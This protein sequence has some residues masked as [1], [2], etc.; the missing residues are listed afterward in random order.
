MNLDL[1]TIQKIIGDSR[2]FASPFDEPC[3]Y[4]FDVAENSITIRNSDIEEYQIKLKYMVENI[5]VL[6]R[7]AVKPGYYDF[8]GVNQNLV[9]S[10]SEMC[11][12]LIVDSFVLNLG[13]RT[14]VCCMSNSQF[15]SGHYIECIWSDTWELIF[16]GIC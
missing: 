4:Y 13:D 5:N 12:R 10:L 16:T 11:Q 2:R 9:S 3:G 8:Y 15:M 14:I 1:F 7:Q 6:I